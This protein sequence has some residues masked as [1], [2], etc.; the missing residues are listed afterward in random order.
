[1]K[2]RRQPMKAR[3]NVFPAPAAALPANGAAQHS[4][5]SWYLDGPLQHLQWR[6]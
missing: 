1:M 3:R 4:R 6:G 5:T 2:V